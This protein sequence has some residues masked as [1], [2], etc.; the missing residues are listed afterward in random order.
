MTVLKSSDLKGPEKLKIDTISQ[1]VIYGTIQGW[2][3]STP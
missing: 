2:D 1:G 3:R